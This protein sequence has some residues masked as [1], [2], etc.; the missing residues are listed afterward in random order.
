MFPSEGAGRIL[1]LVHLLL[2]IVL[3]VV[4]L[5]YYDQLPDQVAVHFDRHGQPDRYAPKSSLT[6]WGIPI[7]GTVMVILSFLLL[8][9][10][11][12]FNHPRKR[13]V[14]ELP[15]DLR[16][17]VY[18]ILRSMMLAIFICMDATMIAVE[19]LIVASAM[20]GTMQMNWPL[21]LVPALLPLAL[22]IV[23]LPKIGRKVDE[24][25]ALAASR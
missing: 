15:P 20:S 17:P 2:L 16:E 22:L 13:E 21:V 7:V 23:Y 11:Q 4:P 1:A 9:F 5:V 3:W 10:P 14:K 12:T 24:M 6:F 18:D 19:Y 8:R 25:K